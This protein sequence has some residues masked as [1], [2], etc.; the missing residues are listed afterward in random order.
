MKVDGS[1]EIAGPV[2]DG[3]PVL[4]RIGHYAFKQART[5]AEFEQA[6]QL[7]YRTFVHEIGQYAD[8]GQDRLVDKFQDKSVYFIG[9]RDDRVVGM[10]T[11][12][13]RPPYSITPRLPDPALLDRLNGRKLEV[14]LLA[15]DPAERNGAVFEGLLFL[16]LLHARRGGYSHML[17]SG[18][19]DRVRLYERLG[20][21]ALGPGVAAGRTAFVPMVADVRVM[22]ENVERAYGRFAGRVRPDRID[23][24]T[25][26]A[27]PERMICLLPGPVQVAPAVRDAFIRPPLYHRTGEF[28]E[29][30]ERVRRVL[31]EMVG[32]MQT[33][34]MCG[35]GTLANDA[36]AAALAA[37][38][39]VRRGVVLINGE[40]G[41]R[42][43]RQA[44]RFGLN[45]ST[46]V[47]PWGKP[48]DLEAL[49]GVLDSDSDINWV[50][51]VHLESSTGLLNDLAG[52]VRVASA[53]RVRV[54]ADCVSSL[55]SVPIDLTGVHLASGAS[56]KSL[57]AY[58]GL[59]F[60]FASAEALAGAQ[61]ERVPTY[62]DVRE[63]LASRGPRFTF[64]SSS[65][66]ALDKALAEYDTPDK[67]QHC[68]ARYAE[69]GRHVRGCLEALGLQPMVGE[70]AAAPVI[71]TFYP[72]QGMSPARFVERCRNWGYE[73][74]GLSNYLK[75]RGLVQ[76]ATMG[77]VQRS[78]LD[79][80][81]ARLSSLPGVAAA[82][83]APA[84]ARA[85]GNGNGNGHV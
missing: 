48:W 60:V 39:M 73:V 77:N 23:P 43:S 29:L 22:P 41:E 46:Q 59:C 44:A 67:R 74:A 78:D 28:I 57:G 65:M 6:H 12:H 64:P 16:V 80:L 26:T 34:V 2:A 45:F 32:G 76:I 15:I 1:C 66:Q 58:A 52:L 14:R 62:L 81:F 85:Q 50:W 55:G 53:R 18:V 61:Y 69:L 63:A 21:R 11:I 31:S 4:I 27:T 42:I 37:D 3:E 70:P 25:A 71:T 30:F 35:S 40:F 68:Y 9:L 17:I 82:L 13:D 79:G 7:N 83:P 20:F 72:P 33:A 36:V 19:R 51:G 56:G 49:A 84:P 5:A 75:E 8:S 47:R 38:P 24:A 10:V 54:C